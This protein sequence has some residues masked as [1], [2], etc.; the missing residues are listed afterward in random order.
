M[1]QAEMMP[2]K[3][4]WEDGTKAGCYRDGCVR[5]GSDYYTSHGGTDPTAIDIAESVRAIVDAA[6]CSDTQMGGYIAGIA[7]SILAAMGHGYPT[8]NIDKKAGEP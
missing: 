1:A 7:C 2:R 6:I 5:I 3:L 4:F 8:I